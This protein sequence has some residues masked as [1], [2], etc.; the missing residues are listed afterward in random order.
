M[1]DHEERDE[2]GVHHVPIEGGTLHAKFEQKQFDDE[3]FAAYVAWMDGVRALVIAHYHGELRGRAP[4]D[5]SFL[6]RF[7]L[8][9]SDIMKGLWSWRYSFS[10]GTVP[11]DALRRLTV[12]LNTFLKSPTAMYEVPEN[13]IHFLRRNVE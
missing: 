12:I 11:E 2:D 7:D 5:F 9:V 13:M 3:L 4:L 8:L 6:E 10:K 1:S